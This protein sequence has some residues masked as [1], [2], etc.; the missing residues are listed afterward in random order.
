VLQDQQ[1]LLEYK[2]APGQ[3][4]Q[5]ALQ[6]QQATNIPPQVQH[7]IRFRVT[8]TQAQSQLVPALHILLVNILLLQIL[9]RFINQPKL[10]TIIRLMDTLHSLQ[11]VQVD[12]EHILSGQLTWLV[13]QVHK[14]PQ[15]QQDRQAVPD[16]QV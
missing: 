13:P 2:E 7:H 8:E 15:D 10:V 3:Q 5:Q 1:V 9:F 16:P 14:D 6:A 4:D 11:Q 12:Q